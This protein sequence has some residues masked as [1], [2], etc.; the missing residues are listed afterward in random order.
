[1]VPIHLLIVI[2]VRSWGFASA[3]IISRPSA[4]VKATESPL[5]LTRLPFDRAG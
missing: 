1:M 3:M 4:A 5:A 2:A